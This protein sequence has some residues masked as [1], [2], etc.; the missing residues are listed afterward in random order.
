MFLELSGPQ[1]SRNLQKRQKMD[2]RPPTFWPIC[3][4]HNYTCRYY[5]TLHY[6][7]GVVIVKPCNLHSDVARSL[8][9]DSSFLLN[10]SLAVSFAYSSIRTVGRALAQRC[11]AMPGI[12]YHTVMGED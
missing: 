6:I 12:L 8:P 2:A 5:S 9:S 3:H 1:P 10:L 4:H 11:D 7:T